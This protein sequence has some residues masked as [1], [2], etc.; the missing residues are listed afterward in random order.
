MLIKNNKTKGYYFH[1]KVGGK[2]FKHFIPALTTVEIANLTN[3]SQIVSSAYDRRIRHI[4][5]KFGYNF[6]TVFEI[7]GDPDFP[8]LTITS[9]SS[10][11]GTISP[12]GAVKV[13]KGENKIFYMVPDTVSFGTSAN[14]LGSSGGTISPSGSTVL[15]DAYYYLKTLTID[16]DSTKVSAVTGNVSAMTTYTFTDVLTSHTIAS[17]FALITGSTTF[18][19]TPD[20][21]YYLK[22]LNLNGSNQV[23][24]ITGSASG[25]STYTLTRI[26]STNTINA[27]FNP[28]GE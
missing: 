11:S 5:D 28:Y 10:L 24:A 18:T 15:S 14:T 17:T 8:T 16:G 9:S 26:S 21:N 6:D 23:S 27:L 3:T 1:Y 20:S 12:S 7:P 4:E 2:I 25:V 19:M 13:A 22:T